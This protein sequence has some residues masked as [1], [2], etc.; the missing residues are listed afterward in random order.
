MYL[1]NEIVTYFDSFGVEHF[2]KET[3]K[4]IGNKNITK[5]ISM[6]REASLII[7]GYFCT[8]FIDFMLKAKSLLDYTHSF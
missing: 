5:T 4:T 1:N 8:A 2:P 7:C 3:N 6:I